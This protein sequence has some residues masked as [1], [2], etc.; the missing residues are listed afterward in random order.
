MQISLSNDGRVF[1]AKAQNDREM[2]DLRGLTVR[3]WDAQNYRWEVAINP[4][5]KRALAPY[6]TDAT[7]AARA[8]LLREG[9]LRRNVPGNHV[10][11]TAPYPH[12]VETI[13]RT[14][15]KDGFGLFLDMGLGKSFCLIN[16]AIIEF[17]QGEI[18]GVAVICPN[19]I[20]SN[21]QDEIALHSSALFS[22]HVY[23]STQKKAA[24]KWLKEQRP[25]NVIPWFII[26]VESLS[27]GEG[28]A[29]LEAFL[30]SGKRSLNLD[31]SSRI[32]NHGATRT[33]KLLSLAPMAKKRRIATG[34]PITRGIQDAWSQFQFLDSSILSMS[35]YAF[36]NRF[37]V[38]G[39]YLGKQVLGAKD[40]ARFIEMTSDHVITILT[41]ECIS[42]P[43]KVYQVRHLKASEEQAR[44]YTTLRDSGMV[45]AVGGLASYNNVLVRELRLQQI[46]G[47][48]VATEEDL[49]AQLRGIEGLDFSDLGQ[50]EA[51]IE[52]KIEKILRPIP[53]PN[54][55]LEELVAIAEECGK[56]MIVWCKYRAE[57]EAVAQALAPLGKV[58]QFHGDISMDDRAE[59]RRSFQTDPNVRFFVAQISTGGIGITLT[60]AS[61]TVYFSNSFSLEERLQ[62]EK[63][64]HRIGQTETCVY[65]DLC[66]GD[67]KRA[68]VD[69][70]VLKALKTKRNYA[71]VVIEDYRRE[72]GLLA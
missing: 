46:A 25:K 9:F 72:S 38:M 47:G 36:R 56:K 71:D 60:A 62:S 7:P 15:G 24:T 59:A 29:F 32:K 33:K 4:E 42:L 57:I 6:V 12:Q 50:W 3:K 40:Q 13:E 30:K 14:L 16:S 23:D 58:V 39:G 53:G 65:I 67:G 70:K 37:C 10:F 11:K 49:L 45:E 34:T 17:N 5:N 26:G 51:V 22:V 55:K 1:L 35:Y 8:E 21:W 28:A 41:E 27:S 68:W 63:R 52:K 54:P 20:K 18:D 64:A 43:E 44:I 66:V 48:F 2:L 69:E 19:S 31:E 61:T